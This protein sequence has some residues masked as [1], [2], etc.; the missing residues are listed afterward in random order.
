[1]YF[2]IFEQKKIIA[3]RVKTSAADSI[4]VLKILLVLLI[5]INY[6]FIKNDPAF[7]KVV[8]TVYVDDAH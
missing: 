5:V 3:P 4:L 7:F 2:C 1:M 8:R 6:Y